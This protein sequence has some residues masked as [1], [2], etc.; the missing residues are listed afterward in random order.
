MNYILQ[1]FL[2]GNEIHFDIQ[3]NRLYRFSV[4]GS[5]RNVSFSSVFFNDTM[6]Q[7]L[8]YLLEHA[9]GKKVTKEEL[10]TNIWDAN[11]LSSS[12]QRLWQVIRKLNKKLMVLGLPCDFIQST[13]GSGYI[14][15]Y[16]DIIPFYFKEAL[17]A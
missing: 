4:N 9:R 16:P 12:T 1:G 8:V 7:L 14:I 3:R 2:I 13:Q 15:N 10:L 6:K 17:E 5:D 11:N